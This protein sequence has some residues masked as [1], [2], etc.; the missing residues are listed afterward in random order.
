M[1]DFRLQNGAGPAY[2]TEVLS[3]GRAKTDSVTRSHAQDESLS[4]NSFN[5][6][7]GTIN[8]TS[9]NATAALY[10]KNNGT[11]AMI[12]E[13]YFY[14]IGNSTNGSG[15][16]L[17]EILRN[18]TTGTIIDGATDADIAGVNRNFGSSKTLTADIY[19]GA[20]GNTF[21]NG[22]AFLYSIFNQ[23]PTRA[24]LDAKATVLNKGD[25]IGFRITPATSNTSLDVQFAM[26]VHTEAI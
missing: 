12:I 23:A 13:D 18:P 15:D 6:N 26:A 1:G 4:G 16:M 21:T 20:E 10:V 22:T 2:F 8:L 25:S 7:T 9:A 5:I 24:R 17:I 14:L 3:N 11:D 19:K